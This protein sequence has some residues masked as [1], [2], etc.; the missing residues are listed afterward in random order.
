[1][2]TKKLFLLIIL[3]TSINIFCSENSEDIEDPNNF[4]SSHTNDTNDLQYTNKVFSTLSISSLAGC[5]G[6]TLLLGDY[7][8]KYFFTISFLIL[9]FLPIGYLI[10]LNYCS[11]RKTDFDSEEMSNSKDS[12]NEETDN[13]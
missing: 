2:I 9:T 5:V 12:N 8:A 11:N 1:M 7:E 3:T 10:K 4:Q 6:S 13:S